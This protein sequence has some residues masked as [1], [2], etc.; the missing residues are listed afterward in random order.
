L[1]SGVAKDVQ[2]RSF[3]QSR[4]PRE[5]EP[6]DGPIHVAL[7]ERAFHPESAVGQIVEH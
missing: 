5:R 3:F 4:L 7:P 2:Q 6:I 1:L